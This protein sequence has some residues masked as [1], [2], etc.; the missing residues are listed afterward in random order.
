MGAEGRA[1]GRQKQ[2][3]AVESKRAA[4][5][6]A[7]AAELQGQATL[8]KEQQKLE[9]AKR[10]QRDEVSTHEALRRS[11]FLAQPTEANAADAPGVAPMAPVEALVQSALKSAPA[12]A[13]PPSA[14]PSAPGTARGESS[15]VP[16][17]V[18]M[19]GSTLPWQ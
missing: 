11:L 5:Q 4:T 10:L 1:Q 9:L 15:A 18:T 3:A 13:P 8:A 17:Q 2:L 12:S 16:A 19:D 14:P 6:E 7:F